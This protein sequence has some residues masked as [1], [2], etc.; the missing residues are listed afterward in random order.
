MS[1]LFGLAPLKVVTTAAKLVSAL[2]VTL[3]RSGRTPV[4]GAAT[5]SIAVATAAVGDLLNVHSF[6]LLHRLGFERATPL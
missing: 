6:S 5:I 4:S 1:K 3:R 2:V